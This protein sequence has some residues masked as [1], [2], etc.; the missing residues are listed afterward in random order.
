MQ[1]FCFMHI[2]SF[3]TGFTVKTDTHFIGVCT[4]ANSFLIYYYISLNYLPKLSVIFFN[5]FFWN[6]VNKLLSQY[7]ISVHL[8]CRL[9]HDTAG[10]LK[11]HVVS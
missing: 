7:H 3:P 11:L 9:A 2:L 6:F 5:N 4:L 8:H 10:L 1:V